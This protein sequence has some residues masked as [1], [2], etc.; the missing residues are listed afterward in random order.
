MSPPR[1]PR[2]AWL[3]LLRTPGVGTATFTA[4]LEAFATPEAFLDADAATVRAA[5][6]NPALRDGTP[7]ADDT[8]VTANLDWL[9][10][11]D[12][13]LITRSDPRYPDGLHA[14]ADPPPLL[15]VNGD[16]AVLARP[17][18]AVVG[19]RKPSRGGEDN[20]H[21]FARYLAGSGLTITSGLALGIDGAAHA[22]ALAGGG[23]TVA[24][25]ATGPDRVY[26]ARHRDLARRIAGGGAI[27]T[28]LPT[29]T[30]VRREQF[31]RRNRLI[32]GLAMGVLVVEAGVHS[33]SLLT[34]QHAL[35]QGRE[36][37]AIPGSI[38]NPM[39]RG[40]HALIR[41]GAKLVES[42]RDVFDELPPIALPGDGDIPA[43]TG[44]G[45]PQA[46]L[47]EDYEQ[48][49]EALGHDPV[50]FDVLAGR[51]GLTADTLSSML[52]I[53]ELKGHVTACSG[54]RYARS[55]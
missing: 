5:G 41:Q 13:H 37:F 22:G 7:G 51:T 52:L 49:L 32:S 40:C 24:V 35:E 48:V 43:D 34:A 29:G 39:A 53:L 10:G 36:V 30:G 12:H 17:Q 4:I 25:T 3:R 44:A 42:A 15:F 26:P 16:P 6:L 1:E 27:V 55:H 2:T 38:H 23:T 50:A 11:P 9:A 21:E 19:S 28:E 54:G 45:A 31:P 33:G 47:G 46:G 20:A 8:G 18:L 14:I